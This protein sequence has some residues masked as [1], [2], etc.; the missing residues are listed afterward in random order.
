MTRESAIFEVNASK[1]NDYE[2]LGR[3][4]VGLLA[5]LGN[6]GLV[7]AECPIC[8]PSDGVV[9]GTLSVQLRMAVPVAAAFEGWLSRHEGERKRILKVRYHNMW[10]VL[11]CMF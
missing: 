4:S 9:I 6:K 11:L 3:S 1:Y 10:T 5:M 2:L 8:R 7:R